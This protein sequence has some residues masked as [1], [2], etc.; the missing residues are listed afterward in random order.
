MGVIYLKCIGITKQTI[1]GLGHH[2]V[3]VE[4]RGWFCGAVKVDLSMVFFDVPSLFPDTCLLR[5]MKVDCLAKPALHA[6]RKKQL[7]IHRS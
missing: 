4:L 6:V 3:V 7:L 2:L 5:H 1:H